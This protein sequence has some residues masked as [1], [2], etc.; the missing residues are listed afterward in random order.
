MECLLKYELAPL[1]GSLMHF[2]QTEVTPGRESGLTQGLWSLRLTAKQSNLLASW[3]CWCHC[4]ISVSEAK[5]TAEKQTAKQKAA[6]TPRTKTD[7]NSLISFFFHGHPLLCSLNH[8]DFWISTFSWFDG[9]LNC[10]KVIDYMIYMFGEYRE[11]S[12]EE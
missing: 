7:S 3:S 5:T 12:E 4:Y 10:Q 11:Y 2:L 6:T 8:C 9:T 1:C